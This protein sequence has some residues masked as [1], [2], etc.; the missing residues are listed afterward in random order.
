MLATYCASAQDSSNS[1]WEPVTDA[2]GQLKSPLVD[3][4]AGVEAIFWKVHVEDQV[5]GGRDGRR[6]LKHY[7]RLKI[8][9]EKGKEAAATIDIETPNRTAIMNAV[10][11]TVKAGGAIVDRSEE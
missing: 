11:R 4:Q 6:L 1:F 10:A 3:T 2:D 7:V 5:L 9:N 8:L